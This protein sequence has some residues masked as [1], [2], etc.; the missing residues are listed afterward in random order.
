MASTYLELPLRSVGSISAPGIASETTLQGVLSELQNISAG[1]GQ[2]LASET[3]FFDYD[4][5]SID[6]TAYRQLLASVADDVKSFTWWESSGV[7]MV[8][9]V[10]GVGS[11]VDL[12]T[13]PPGGFNGEIPMNIPAGS[14]LSIKA[15]TADVVEVGTYIV[16]NFYK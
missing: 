5:H 6:N 14:R 9:A 4:A 2:K 11:E 15:L 16:A 7:P 3:L 10:G 8:I 12:F 1:M 13:T